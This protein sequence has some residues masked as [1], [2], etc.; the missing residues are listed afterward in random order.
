MIICLF[1]VWLHSKGFFRLKDFRWTLWIFNW[2]S[3]KTWVF[4]LDWEGP[5]MNFDL[6]KHKEIKIKLMVIMI[7][8]FLSLF[9]FYLRLSFFFYLFHFQA[10]LIPRVDISNLQK[11]LFKMS[12]TCENYF[13]INSV[14]VLSD[15]LHFM[16]YLLLKF[17]SFSTGKDFAVSR[18][19]LTVL[20]QAVQTRS[21]RV[22]LDQHEL[23]SGVYFMHPR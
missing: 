13:W 9:F 15:F 7:M 17:Y 19:S 1:K 12:R 5:L 18:S 11:M 20:N 10:L 3:K 2:M 21:I 14:P 22:L 4:V 8:I 23:V 16:Q 6:P